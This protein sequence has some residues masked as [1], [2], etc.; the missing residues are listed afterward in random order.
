[1]IIH[2]P[3]ENIFYD[4]DVGPVLLYVP[5]CCFLP[6]CDEVVGDA[7]GDPGG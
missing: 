5:Y 1:M 6:L 4:V 7:R 3:H 2:G